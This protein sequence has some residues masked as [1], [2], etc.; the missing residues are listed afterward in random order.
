MLLIRSL[1]AI[2][3][4]MIL[5]QATWAQPAPPNACTE[6]DRTKLATAAANPSAQQAA[7]IV[8]AFSRAPAAG[9]ADLVVD[10]PFAKDNS[11]LT[12]RVV[13]QLGQPDTPTGEKI[14]ILENRD[15][16]AK[17]VPDGY[18]LRKSGAVGQGTTLLSFQVPEILSDYSLLQSG[19]IA[20]IGCD[21]KNAISFIGHHYT[22]FS[23]RTPLI[24]L[25]GFVGI[26]LYVLVA[27]AVANE[28]NKIRVPQ[29]KWYRFLDPVV[30]SS[31]PNG[32]GSIS[33]LQ[34]LFFSVLL[35]C[36]LF[37]ILVRVGLLSDM[38][39]TVL[40]L[41]GISG[42]GAAAANGT[43]TKRKR[44]K[45]E[46]WAWLLN[47]QWL[48]AN[49]VAS[50]NIAKWRDIVSGAGGFDVYRFQMLIFSLVVGLALLQLGFA[51]LSSF[52]I[53]A[54]LLGVLGLS[55]VIYI[56]GKLVD[57]P[58]VQ[59]LD[60]A[61]D[62]LIAAESSFA[63]AAVKQGIA[64]S[65]NPSAPPAAAVAAMPEYRAFATQRDLV[66]TMFESLFGKLPTGA[67]REPR[68]V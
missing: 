50:V 2:A 49:G 39:S 5:H 16:I 53:P 9:P 60:A 36:L 59:D 61:L 42:V 4:V 26:A 21:D 40:L 32:N 8:L 10:R 34:I 37:Y 29:L 28:E 48:P 11:K 25:T 31:D 24:L 62:K 45:F 20:V 47:K 51:E 35:F 46:N 41:L 66:V 55:Q 13:F 1:M 65:T 22:V 56:G 43:D 68:Y 67:Y 18:S 17:P 54:A 44:L 38:S 3:I 64:G 58:S 23:N 15:I 52:E 30:L 6:T 19:A 27:I 7:E 12:Y 57:A 33:R 63:D 14:R